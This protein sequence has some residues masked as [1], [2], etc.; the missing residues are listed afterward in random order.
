MDKTVLLSEKPAD[1]AKIF[2]CLKV[3][4]VEEITLKEFD[5]IGRKSSKSSANVQIKSPII[6]RRHGE[7]SLKNGMYYYRDL[8]SL[9]GTY[10]NDVMY[11]KD[12]NKSPVKLKNGDVLRIGKR[13]AAST[14]ANSVLIIFMNVVANE[15]V[16][17]HISTQLHQTADAVEQLDQEIASKF[18]AR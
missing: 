11:K 2:V 4:H 6:S 17:T 1:S 5:I 3:D 14:N 9:N 13:T 15:T 10:I 18:G 7:F 8:D 16:W 12:S